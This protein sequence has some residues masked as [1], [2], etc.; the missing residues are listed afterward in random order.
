MTNRRHFGDKLRKLFDSRQDSPML[1]MN[2]RAFVFRS[3][4]NDENIRQV[5][6]ELLYLVRFPIMARKY[7]TE[8]VSKKSLLSYEEII[9]VYQSLDD[10]EL[11]VFP[12]KRRNIEH[13]V[14]RRCDTSFHEKR[15]SKHNWI[16][17]LSFFR[18]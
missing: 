10:Q 16:H 18:I 1:R 8:N 12:T 9:N 3:S 5:L 11:A 2:V 13:M 15:L 14:C 6:G 4:V 7:F 17:F